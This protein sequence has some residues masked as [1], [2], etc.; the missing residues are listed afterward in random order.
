MGSGQRHNNR[1]IGADWQRT[2]EM[3]PYEE[4]R[5][6]YARELPEL[7]DAYIKTGRME[8]DPYSLEFTGWLTPIE[9]QVWIS[10]RGCGLPFLPQ[11]PV[12]NYFIDFA[13]PFT[14]I[15]IECDGKEWHNAERDAFRDSR[16]E[17]EGWTIYRIPGWQCNKV[18]DEPW[19][20]Y[21]DLPREE[22]DSERRAKQE[23]AERWFGTTAD[24]IVMAIGVEHFDYRVH[25]DYRNAAG[26]SVREH[27]TTWPV[28]ALN[29]VKRQ[30]SSP[31]RMSETLGNYTD[32][33]EKRG[34]NRR[35]CDQVR[36]IIGQVK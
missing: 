13:N 18:M 21:P 7:Q 20:A 6:H 16:L 17:K 23:Y 14:K 30:R 26:K 19:E 33:L 5:R 3:I 24:G 9:G 25:G 1:A 10:I 28:V 35:V 31:V 8:F 34:L 27:R 11:L 22:F 15:G 36:V 2:F 29:A 32:T 12:L 4:I